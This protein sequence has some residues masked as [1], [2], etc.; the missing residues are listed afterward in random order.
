MK[1]EE[2]QREYWNNE[3]KKSSKYN[4]DGKFYER[5]IRGTR[6]QYVLYESVH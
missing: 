3:V 6:R 1:D 2:E 5:I 4:S